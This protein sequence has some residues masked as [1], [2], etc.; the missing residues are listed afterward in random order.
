MFYGIVRMKR[1]HHVI[2]VSTVDYGSNTHFYCN[3]PFIRNVILE[4]LHNKYTVVYNIDRIR[5][6]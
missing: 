3:I 1:K 5:L 4:M 2:T 6:L